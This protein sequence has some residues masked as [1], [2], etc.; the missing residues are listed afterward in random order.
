MNAFTSQSSSSRQFIG[1]SRSPVKYPGYV[2]TAG[3]ERFGIRRKQVVQLAD[4]RPGV[5]V[6][7]LELTE[8]RQM[9]LE[10]ERSRRFLDALVAAVPVPLYVKDRAHRWVELNDAFGRLMNRPREELVGSTD[11]AVMPMDA[12]QASYAEDDAAFASTGLVESEM[13]LAMPERPAQWFLKHKQAVTLSDGQQYVIA[14][15]V[16]ITQRKRAEQDLIHAEDE[17]RRHRDRLQDLVLE[18][19]RELEAAKEAAERANRSKSEFLAN[20]SHELRTPLH[21]ILSFARLGVDR[22][23]HVPAPV[24]KFEQY[25][26]RIQQS[27]DRLLV[28]LNDLLDVAKLEAGKMTYDMDRCDVREVL[29]AALQ[30]LSALGGSR[31]VALVLEPSTCDP[32]AWCDAVRTGQVVRNL[33]SN[34]IKFSPAGGS[35]RLSLENAGADDAPELLVSVCDEGPGIPEDEL[36]S[37]F[38]KFVQS[39]KTKSGA[40]GT[41]LGLAICQRIVL[42]HGGHI[43]AENLGGAGA[44]FAFILPRAAREPRHEPDPVI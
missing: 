43:W 19:T 36:E 4:G 35:V 28:L 41:G 17:L 23:G 40:G 30:E 6:T 10:L 2:D 14:M 13:H 44:R 21:A 1:Y 25:F 38:D 37:I 29:R 24:H 5:L 26:S 22:V 34:A 11:S 3:R 7:Y 9:E 18:R 20:M 39:T 12:A 31:N 27:G 42:D 15:A 32:H 16:D 33:L 8:R